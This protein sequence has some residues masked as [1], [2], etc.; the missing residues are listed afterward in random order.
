MN[1]RPNDWKNPYPE[2]KLAREAFIH[3][4]YDIYEA[5]AG[6]MLEAL[7]KLAAESPTKTFTID[8]RIINTYARV[9]DLPV[10]EEDELATTA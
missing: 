8:S 3:V 1:W 5:G 2:P 4:Y 10:K 7:F 6:A 9:F